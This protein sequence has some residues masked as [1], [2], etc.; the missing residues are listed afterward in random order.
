[1]ITDDILLPLS[2][3]LLRVVVDHFHGMYVPCTVYNYTTY[4]FVIIMMIV[5]F[6]YPKDTKILMIDC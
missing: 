3:V 5:N 1:V 4:N 2:T 6:V